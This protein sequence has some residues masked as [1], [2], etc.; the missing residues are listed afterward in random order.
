MQVTFY[1]TGCTRCHELKELLDKKN[2]VYHTVTSVEEMLNL[3][4]K[5]APALMV[6]DKLYDYAGAV[7]WIN[8]LTGGVQ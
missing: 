6:D 4:L 3:G 1:T 5:Y 7:S 8:T 2:V